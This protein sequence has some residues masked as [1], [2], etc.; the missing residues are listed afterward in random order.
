[1]LFT[2]S[3]QQKYDALRQIG[4]SWNM[5]LLEGAVVVRTVHW[6]HP[7]GLPTYKDGA[8]CCVQYQLTMSAD[9]AGISSIQP[10][11]MR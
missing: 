8:C 5:K 7:F 2:S 3:E 1:M 10:K 9:M 6:P 4:R 11:H